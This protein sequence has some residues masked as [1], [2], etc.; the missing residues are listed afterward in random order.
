MELY[1]WPGNVRELIN[2]VQNAMVMCEGRLIT[3]TDLGIAERQEA[4]SGAVSLQHARHS[5]ERDLILTALERNRQNMA[6]TAR[7]LG[8]SRVTLYRLIQKLAIARSSAIRPDP[9]TPS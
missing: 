3:P 8:V 6:A 9:D 5:T 1:P 7:E 4:N 2:R